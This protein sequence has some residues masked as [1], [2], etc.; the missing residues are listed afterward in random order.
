MTRVGL[1]EAVACLKSKVANKTSLE[2]RMNQQG[3]N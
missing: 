1:K 3:E 2:M